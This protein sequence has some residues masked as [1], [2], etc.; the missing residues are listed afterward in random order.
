MRMS[1]NW[2]HIGADK[3]QREHVLCAATIIPN[4]ASRLGGQYYALTCDISHFSESPSDGKL[5][6]LKR[7]T[8][9]AIRVRNE[10]KLGGGVASDSPAHLAQ[11]TI[12]RIRSGSGSTT[13]TVSSPFAPVEARRQA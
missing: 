4:A 2:C 8:I 5:H 1:V 7:R 6:A 13:T 11:R 3:P 12:A 9:P 10:T